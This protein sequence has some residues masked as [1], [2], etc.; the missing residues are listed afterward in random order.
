[1]NLFLTVGTQLPFDRLTRAVDAWL[2]DHPEYAD[3]VFGQIGPVGRAPLA[4]T[5]AAKRSG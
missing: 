5:T 4:N 1:M 3:H 2:D